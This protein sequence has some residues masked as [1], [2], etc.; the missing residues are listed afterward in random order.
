[1]SRF[2][3]RMEAM[4]STAETA[5]LSNDKM[6]ESADMKVFVE[7]PFMPTLGMFLAILDGDDHRKVKDIYWSKADGFEIYFEAEEQWTVAELEKIGWEV[8]EDE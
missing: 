4:L 7:L 8:A 1:M 6:I 5:K 2:E 3:F